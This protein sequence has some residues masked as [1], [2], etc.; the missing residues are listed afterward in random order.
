[1][2]DIKVL[3]KI[4]PFNELYFIN[5]FYNS[6]FS[7]IQ[8]YNKSIIPVLVN[9]ILE[10]DYIK[11][12]DSVNIFSK[13]I[14]VRDLD[15]ILNSIGIQCNAKVNNEYILEDTLIALSQNR[16]IIIDV[17]C[18]YMP[19]RKEYLNTH[20]IHLILICGYDNITETFTIIEQKFSDTLSYQVSTIRYLDLVKSYEG[21]IASL[22]EMKKEALYLEFDILRNHKEDI[23][24]K[25]S[26][27][28]IIFIENF[29][30]T[31]SHVEAGLK[32]LKDFTYDSRLLLAN[33]KML[34]LNTSNLVSGFNTIINSKRVEYYKIKEIFGEDHFLTL[35]VAKIES[36]WSLI[37]N[38]CVKFSYSSLYRQSDFLPLTSLIDE[39]YQD[40]ILFFNFL[41]EQ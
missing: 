35:L 28:K 2:E 24:N 39:I 19:I 34:K 30:A 37:R 1:M 9:F 23:N 32:M 12:T 14:S 8:F 5:C 38:K 6:L 26:D 17:D 40:E 10:Y 22:S 15:Q 27:N 33:E 3:D 20:Y 7:I 21:V 41:I 13:Y 25:S 4:K 29:K 11:D 36:N 18:Y 31:A 16:P